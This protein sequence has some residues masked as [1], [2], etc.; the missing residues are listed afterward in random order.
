M[1]SGGIKWEHWPEIGNG[2]TYYFSFI[3][4][5][6]MFLLTQ[7]IFTISQKNITT[8]KRVFLCVLPKYSAKIIS[9]KPKMLFFRKD[10][11]GGVL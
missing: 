10:C 9:Q 11:L 6:K 3:K 1:F 7:K 8:S 5:R 2:H 4:E